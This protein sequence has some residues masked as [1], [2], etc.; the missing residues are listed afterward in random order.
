MKHSITC[1]T[2]ADGGYCSRDFIGQRN[3][4]T[5]SHDDDPKPAIE[6]GAD[7]SKEFIDDSGKN[8]GVFRGHIVDIDDDDHDDVLYNVLCE[9]GDAED[10]N[11]EE[12]G[13]AIDLYAYMKLES[14]EINEWEIGG[15]E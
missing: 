13:A 3:L 8:Q 6:L 14:E 1:F 4:P 11:E 10:M 5:N 12:C 2:G 15:D 9:G 7:I